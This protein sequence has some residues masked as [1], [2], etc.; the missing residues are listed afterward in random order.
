MAQEIINLGGSA[1]DGTGDTLRS[2]GAKINSNFTEIYEALANS[3]GAEVS[4]ETST[5]FNAMPNKLHVITNAGTTTGILPA[6]PSDGDT[7]HFKVTNGL[8]TN[9]IA[10]NSKLI[11]GFSENLLLDIPNLYITLK[12]F[13]SSLQWRVL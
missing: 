4:I 1:N 2:G 6:S 11:E 8:L 5:T 10:R 12:Y 9:V 13:N 7:I 3:S